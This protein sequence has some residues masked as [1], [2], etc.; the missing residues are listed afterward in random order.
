MAAAILFGAGGRAAFQLHG[1]VSLI[2]DAAGL[3]LFGDAGA[4]ITLQVV[5]LQSWGRHPTAN[6]Y[7]ARVAL[8]EW[9]ALPNQ[10]GPVVRASDP[11][12]GG[13]HATQPKGR[14]A[15]LADARGIPLLFDAHAVAGTVGGA[16]RVRQRAAGDTDPAIPLVAD[17]DGFVVEN[18]AP[19]EIRAIH[20]EAVRDAGR[21]DRAV[22]RVALTRGL[23]LGG[24]DARAVLGAGDALAGVAP[25]RGAGDRQARHEEHRDCLHRV[26]RHRGTSRYPKMVT[27]SGVS[28]QS[29][30]GAGDPAGRA[31]A[32]PS[33]Q[34]ARSAAQEGL[35][36]TSGVLRGRALRF[37]PL[38]PAD[39]CWGRLCRYCT[40]AHPRAT[41]R[42]GQ[43]RP[44]RRHQARYDAAGR[45]ADLHPRPVFGG[46]GAA[47]ADSGSGRSAQRQRAKRS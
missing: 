40:V 13:G 28:V 19:A 31:Q 37:R 23:T 24:G 34:E 1:D 43:D 21:T 30:L 10:A 4:V 9:R 15:E 33:H 16:A 42:T 29:V 17:T 22:G 25:V 36:A 39:R 7:E 2:A 6:G 46:R 14:I 38:S 47:R 45:T 41:R 18:H 35:R 20:L 44:P 8:A 5:T 32:L 12:T 11:V 27:E 26:V 3:A